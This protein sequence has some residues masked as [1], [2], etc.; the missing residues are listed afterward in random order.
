MLSYALL[1]ALVNSGNR[2]IVL[3]KI[4]RRAAEA[5]D[6]SSPLMGLHNDRLR[7]CGVSG[8]QSDLKAGKKNA[9][10]VNHLEVHV[11][12]ELRDIVLCEIGMRMER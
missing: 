10:P 7:T 4:P 3:L 11:L 8:N 6:G 5:G 12:E 1:K 9:I 2:Q